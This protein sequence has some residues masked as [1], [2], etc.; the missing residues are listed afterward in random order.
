M[1]NNTTGA[2]NTAVGSQALN[3]NTT[4]SN[5]TAVGYQAGYSNTTGSGNTFV[6]NT[7]GYSAI[8]TNNTVLGYQ[9]GYN[10]S[11]ARNTIVGY[12][13]GFSLTTGTNNTFVGGADNGNLGAGYYVTTGS[14]N[15]ILG[16]Y[17]GNGGGL[18]IRT[19]SNYIVLS[20]GDGNPRA[21]F[22][23]S[24]Y[25]YPSTII[26]LPNSASTSGQINYYNCGATP[27]ILDTYPLSNQ[28]ISLQGVTDNLYFSSDKSGIGNILNMSSS[29]VTAIQFA[30]TQ[31]ASSNAN[32]LDDYEEGTWT[33]SFGFGTSGSAIYSVQSGSYVKIGSLIT[34]SAIIVLSSKN[35]ASGS[36]FVDLPFNSNGG[37][38]SSIKYWTI[39]YTSNNITWAS[40]S[41]GISAQIGGNTTNRLNFYNQINGGS[42]T[43]LDVSQFSNSTEL[44][45]TCTYQTSP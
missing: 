5:N 29:G 16:A 9:A 31:V 22:G 25:F 34:V 1:Y 17:S 19:A 38:G 24:G 23:P 42:K 35:T 14:K 28:T 12:D 8:G 44:I 7:A 20:D 18:D 32:T 27:I 13:A 43:T 26:N 2:Q 4:A 40:S 6:G 30:A 15:T 10:V 45:F 33:P 36:V 21:Y 39:S 11:G 37:S 3:S 41:Y